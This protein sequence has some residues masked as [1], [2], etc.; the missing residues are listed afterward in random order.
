M[1]RIIYL[2]LYCLLL[3]TFFAGCG[4]VALH[5]A[6]SD[7]PPQEASEQK[8]VAKVTT[9]QAVTKVEPTYKELCQVQ[10]KDRK[11]ISVLQR[12]N[13]F[14]LTAATPDSI[15]TAS[16]KELIIEQDCTL[17][18]LINKDNPLPKD[19]SPKSLT[20]ISASKV[21]LEYP[22]LK[23]IP[24]TLDAL[25]SMAAA[26]KEDGIKGFIINSAYRSISIQQFI[27]NSNLE[28]FKKTS[29]TYE[30][31][32]SRT[33]QLVALPGNSEH[34]TGLSLDIFSVNGR[35]RKDFEGT[36]EQIWLD[37]N[38][39]RFGFIIRYPSDKTQITGSVYEP[40]HIR[41][42]GVS[43]S[44]YLAEND[45][46]LEEFYEKTFKGEILENSSSV[47][48]GVGSGQKVYIDSHL[49]DNVSLEI[50]NKDNSLLTVAK[51]NPR[52]LY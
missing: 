16:M 27:F 14:Y 23:L 46:C 45:L 25:Y 2:F 29:K 22:D 10:L 38:L 42:V 4:K 41:Y 18:L 24:C 5:K 26:A 37:K 19:F 36:K 31:A 40:W 11:I 3:C 8:F 21:K 33:R 15:N 48:I 1:R 30:E 51:I 20:P 7:S 47:F 9:E 13:T 32:F 35:H 44:T 39:H 52:G 17:K 6:V 12:D 49:L 28:N 50:V 34:H 43:L